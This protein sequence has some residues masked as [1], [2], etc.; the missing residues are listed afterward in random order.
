MTAGSER[1]AAAAVG[2]CFQAP[3]EERKAGAAK[4]DD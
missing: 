1:Y 2:G 4:E 3:V